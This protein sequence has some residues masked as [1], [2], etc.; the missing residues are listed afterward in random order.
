[1]S[2]MHLIS[3]GQN[4]SVER[5]ASGLYRVLAGDRLLG[6]VE[7][8]G[9][10]YVALSGSRY[11]RAVEAGQAL[12]LAAAVALLR[13]AQPDAQP[14]PTAALSPVRTLVRVLRSVA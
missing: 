6:F 8:A 12:S 5:Q 7:R 9:S 11:N 1:M 2:T 13:T 14:Q 4:Y 3:N 10:V